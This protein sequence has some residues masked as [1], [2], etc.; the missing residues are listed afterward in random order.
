M[1]RES[2]Q[3]KKKH[4]EEL[5]AQRQREDAAREQHKPEAGGERFKQEQSQPSGKRRLPD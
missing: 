5:I 1:D 4:R 3:N 2:R